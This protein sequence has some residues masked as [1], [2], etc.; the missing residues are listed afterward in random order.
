MRRLGRQAPGNAD[1]APQP[2][3]APTQRRRRRN[4]PKSFSAINRNPQ[5]DRL[6]EAVGGAVE[7]DTEDDVAAH[8]KK[9]TT[10][11]ADALSC[12]GACSPSSAS[13]APIVDAGSTPRTTF[14]HCSRRPAGLSAARLATASLSADSSTGRSAGEGGPSPTLRDDR[15]RAITLLAMSWSSRSGAA[16]SQRR[17]GQARQTDSMRHR[18]RRSRTCRAPSELFRHAQH[19]QPRRCDKPSH[20]P[21]R[22]GRA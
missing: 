7:G 4:P 10:G 19:S 3:S 21:H 12:S 8:L 15:R 16:P 1:P 22:I 18:L 11:D 17:V 6:L 2:L 5:S 14:R 9:D 13:L 20:A